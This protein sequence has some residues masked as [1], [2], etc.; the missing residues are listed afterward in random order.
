MVMAAAIAPLVMPSVSSTMSKL[1]LTPVFISRAMNIAPIAYATYTT[2]AGSGL[3]IACVAG[4][5]G[6]R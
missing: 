3:V 6:V 2:S 4:A 5:I 1:R